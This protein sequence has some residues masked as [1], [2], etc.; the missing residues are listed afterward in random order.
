[1]LQDHGVCA[2][3][4]GDGSSKLGYS[5]YS[6]V[7]KTLNISYFINFGPEP[8]KRSALYSLMFAP[9]CFFKGINEDSEEMNSEETC[10]I[11]RHSVKL[12][13]I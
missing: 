2:R 8:V 4:R 9:Y 1:M 12:T 13:Q 6:T 10:Q 3:P 7:S 11:H 5:L